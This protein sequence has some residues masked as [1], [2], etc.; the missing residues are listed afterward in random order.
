M[1]IGN[2]NSFQESEKS[3]CWQDILTLNRITEKFQTVR[4]YTNYASSVVTLQ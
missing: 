1:S 4:R 3:R 2:L